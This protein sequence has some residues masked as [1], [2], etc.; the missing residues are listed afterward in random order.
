MRQGLRKGT[1]L[2]CKKKSLRRTTR[3]RET[4]K[5]PVNLYGK[6]AEGILPT[7]G[8]EVIHQKGKQS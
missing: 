2:F 5:N 6:T 4:E 8:E 1:H 3:I 7:D